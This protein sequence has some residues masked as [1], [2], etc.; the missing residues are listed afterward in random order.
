MSAKIKL[1]RIGAKNQPAYRVV[2]QDESAAIRSRVVAILGQ[3]Q[4]LR[5][6]ALFEVKKE[7]TLDWIKKGAKPTPKVR[8]LL[9]KAG[10]L[11]ALDLQSLP[12]KKKKG[13]TAAAEPAAATPAAAPP[14]A[15]EAAPAAP[16]AAPEAQA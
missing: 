7:A 11:P 8:I 16:A 13:E 12:K 15:A 9:G 10:I 5:E 14:A 6:P 4:P 1:Q 2:V 3:Y